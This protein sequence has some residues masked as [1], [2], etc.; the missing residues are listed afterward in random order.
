VRSCF[1]GEIDY[2]RRLVGIDHVGVGTD[3]AGLS[4]FT[5]IPTYRALASVPAALLARGFREGEVRKLLGGNFLRVFE[6]VTAG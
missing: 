1:I 5:S 4:T 3:M 6:A 2:V